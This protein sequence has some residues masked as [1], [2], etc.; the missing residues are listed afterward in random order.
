MITP[1]RKNEKRVSPPLRRI[2]DHDRRVARPHP[3][4]NCHDVQHPLG[5]LDHF[6]G[7]LVQTQDIRRQNH[8]QPA[9]QQTNQDRQRQRAP[10]V[11]VGSLLLPAPMRLPTM[12]AVAWARPKVNTK[13][14]FS[15][16]ATMFIAA[17]ESVPMRA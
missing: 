3:G 10:G 6:R 9:D 13:A 2:A 8:H 17:R 16:D 11:L 14:M 5:C 15:M 1:S 7:H 12:M 4:E